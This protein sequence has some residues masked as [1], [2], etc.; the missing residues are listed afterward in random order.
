[1]QLVS[2]LPHKTAQQVLD[3]YRN[4]KRAYAKAAQLNYR[5]GGLDGGRSGGENGDSKKYVK[6]YSRVDRADKV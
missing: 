1:M 4:N 3:K 5:S 6:N 2:Q